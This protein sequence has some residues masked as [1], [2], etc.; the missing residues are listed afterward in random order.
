MD[1]ASLLP[2][3]RRLA[4]DIS[5]C[6]QNPYLGPDTDLV[7]KEVVRIGILRASLGEGFGFKGGTGE[8]GYAYANLQCAIYSGVGVDVR[9]ASK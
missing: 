5:K 7:C 2:R 9:G 6:T 3:A 1:D 8:F 4:N